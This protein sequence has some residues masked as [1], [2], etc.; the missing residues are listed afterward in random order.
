MP[1][2][3]QQRAAALDA[4]DDWFNKKPNSPL[5]RYLGTELHV[6][7]IRALLTEQGPEIVTISSLGD[8]IYQAS[9]K[10][11]FKDY[12]IDLTPQQSLAIVKKVFEN[13]PQGIIV[14][15]KA[16]PSEETTVDDLIDAMDDVYESGLSCGKD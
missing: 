10:N 7:T 6:P 9:V 8:E 16:H 1:I 12:Y 13:R 11:Q 4:W 3:P 5:E 14:K 15:D 2:T